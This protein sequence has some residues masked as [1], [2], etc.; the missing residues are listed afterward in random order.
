MA[1]FGVGTPECR[2]S[3]VKLGRARVDALREGAPDRI[4]Q[5]RYR[6]KQQRLLDGEPVLLADEH[7]V[8]T[9][10]GDGQPSAL[11]TCSTTNNSG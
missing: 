9:L 4:G 3:P 5:P 2:D 10:A 8:A 6:L 11:T 1:F 7:R